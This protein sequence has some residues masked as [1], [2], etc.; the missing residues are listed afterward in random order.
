[1]LRLSLK[2]VLLLLR[3]DD[4]NDV[5][6]LKVETL[7]LSFYILFGGERRHDRERKQLGVGT[8]TRL[9]CASQNNNASVVSVF[10]FGRREKKKERKKERP[11]GGNFFIRA[12]HGRRRQKER[13]R[14][15][16]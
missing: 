1:M 15:R 10:F 4:E 14:E 12:L 8:T 9:P 16:R 7:N 3:F 11:V 2:R 5:S 13:E 6:L